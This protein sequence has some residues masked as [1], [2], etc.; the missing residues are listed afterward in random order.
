MGTY[1][2]EVVILGQDYTTTNKIYNSH[3]LH[4]QQNVVHRKYAIVVKNR[5][6]EREEQNHAT[7]ITSI[8]N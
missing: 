5:D 3:L 4:S 8:F 7:I 1:K 6:G 2:T